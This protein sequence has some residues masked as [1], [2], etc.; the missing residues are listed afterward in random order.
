MRP[1]LG[2]NL[3]QWGFCGQTCCELMEFTGEKE[4]VTFLFITMC[5]SYSSSRGELAECQHWLYPNWTSTCQMTGN[6]LLIQLEFKLY[7]SWC[8]KLLHFSNT[9]MLCKCNLK[10]TPGKILFLCFHYRHG[11]Y[12]DAKL[13]PNIKC[14]VRGSERNRPPAPL[15]TLASHSWTSWFLPAGSLA[16]WWANQGW[17]EDT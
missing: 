8:W 15:F 11:P 4:L 2:Q 14:S 9:W 16:P 7:P 17:L 12:A 13:Q 10:V 3:D 6:V 5:Q 1:A